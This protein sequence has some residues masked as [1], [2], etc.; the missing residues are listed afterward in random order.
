M[1]MHVDA[2]LVADPRFQLYGA[3]ILAGEGLPY[4][5]FTKV[6]FGTNTFLVYIFKIGY[7]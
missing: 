6:I 7:K 5:N 1:Q 2:N 4:N 3:K